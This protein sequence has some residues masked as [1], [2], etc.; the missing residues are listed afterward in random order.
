MKKIYLTIAIALTAVASVV[1]QNTQ[2]NL[3]EDVIAGMNQVNTALD[4]SKIQL[5][6]APVTINAKIA[7]CD[8]LG[9]R[10]AGGNSQNGNM[11]DLTNTS[12][13]SIQITSFDQC[14]ATI[15]VA[16]SVYILYK[17]G[18]FVGSEA[19]MSA[20]TLAGQFWMTPTASLVPT[21]IP[22]PLTINIPAGGTYG[23]YITRTGTNYVA[24]TN[25]NAQGTAMKT[26]SGLEF[27]EGR[28]IAF[29]FGSAFGTAPASRIWN[30]VIHFCSPLITGINGIEINESENVVYPNPSINNVNVNVSTS[31]GIDN[32]TA[33]VYD[34]SGRLVYSQANIN[35]NNFTV[36]HNLN[37]GLYVLQ[38]VN[39]G[40]VVLNKKISVQ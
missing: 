40:T 11:F 37:S 34:L 26:K 24:Y 31:I 33:N 28:G 10:W 8:T 21:A 25:G 29:P 23:F 1:G 7:G 18:T 3:S 32:A 2:A 19:T 22:V 6:K 39:A 12:T 13:V 9:T 4:Y 27:K 5:E 17:S 20:W 14:F 15:G 38:V 36:N 30:G 35:N 16:D